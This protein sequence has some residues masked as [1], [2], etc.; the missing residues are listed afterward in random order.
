RAPRYNGGTSMN[1]PMHPEGLADVDAS[2]ALS[3]H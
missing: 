2:H 1:E 3:R